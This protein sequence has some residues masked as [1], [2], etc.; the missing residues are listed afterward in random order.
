MPLKHYKQGAPPT[1]SAMW[2]CP[3]CKA[4]NLGRLEDGCTSCGAGADAKPAG[5]GAATVPPVRTRPPAPALQEFTSGSTHPAFETWWE[6][7]GKGLAGELTARQLALTAFVVGWDGHTDLVRQLAAHGDAPNVHVGRTPMG[8]GN[9]PPEPTTLEGTY[10]LALYHPE[11]LTVGQLDAKQLNTVVAA[12]QF[13]KENMLVFGEV[14][15]QLTPE[16]VDTF[17]SQ[18]KDPYAHTR[19]TEAGAG[20][21]ASDPTS[22]SRGAGTGPSGVL[23]DDDIPL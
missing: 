22:A 12:L 13:Y 10:V 8:S 16:E 3:S 6:V 1:A 2:K 7:F 11:A 9:E 18:L 5:K 23:S 19:E 20:S 15:D 4:E 14:E 17:L 21:S